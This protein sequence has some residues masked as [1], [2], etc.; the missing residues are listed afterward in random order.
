MR[1]ILLRAAVMIFLVLNVIGCASTK[2]LEERITAL[3]TLAASTEE[4]KKGET[5]RLNDFR[6]AWLTIDQK[7]QEYATERGMT[8]DELIKETENE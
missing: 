5:D 2:H 6:D 1:R 8:V 4:W 3:E 7:I